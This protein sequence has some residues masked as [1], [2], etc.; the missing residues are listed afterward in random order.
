MSGT[1]EGQE[2]ICICEFMH[3]ESA[4]VAVSTDLEVD[5]V[6]EVNILEDIL[7]ELDVRVDDGIKV[8]DLRFRAFEIKTVRVRVHR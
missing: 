4:D 6:E 2:L 3:A 8:V 1:A 7:G 5:K